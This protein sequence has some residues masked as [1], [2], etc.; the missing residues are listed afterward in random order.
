MSEDLCSEP[1]VAC[2]AERIAG[3]PAALLEASRA[4]LPA[5]IAPRTVITTGIGASEGPA[6]LLAAYLVESGVAARFVSLAT[7]AHA[8]QSASLLVLF[9]QNLSPNARLALDPAH[10]FD[11]R[12]LVTSVGAA[13]GASS[14]EPLLE[15]LRAEGVVPIVTPPA[16]EDGM[17]VRVVGPAAASLV[18]LRLAA[19]LGATALAR[20]SFEEA[21]TVYAS[22]AS[23][24]PLPG[25]DFAL[26]A[27]GVPV[28]HLHGLRWKVLETLLRADPSVWDVLQ[29]AHGPLQTIHDRPMTM[30][31]FEAGDAA[32]LVARLE[33][34]LDPSRH[35][36]VRFVATRRDAL[37]FFEHTARLDACLLATLRAA[38][39]DL[40]V[41]PG[42]G[43]D[44]PLYD[45]G[46][47]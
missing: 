37:A 43:R 16:S 1:S 31:V 13:V 40:Y 6:R 44:A 9:S 10:A 46:E 21:A 28:E 34:T 35:R 26:V 39:R 24:A 42:L 47:R 15:A 25:D 5:P 36:L 7:F 17:L 8:R 11:A 27:A 2:L 45:L 33:S 38:P 4:P 22:A 12:W 32:P 19:A 3:I 41:W 30:L 20:T 14:R 23:A 29:I 18:A